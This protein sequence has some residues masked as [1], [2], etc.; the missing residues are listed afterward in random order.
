MGLSHLQLCSISDVVANTLNRIHVNEMF[1]C[2][3]NSI[4]YANHDGNI[5]IL[6]DRKKTFSRNDILVAFSKALGLSDLSELRDY[7]ENH[8]VIKMPIDALSFLNPF[9]RSRY[10]SF[11]WES[12]GKVF[13]GSLFDRQEL[14]VTN[15]YNSFKIPELIELA[16]F[17][18][19]GVGNAVSVKFISNDE[20]DFDVE[21]DY[22][23]KKS[24]DLFFIAQ[25]I[26]L[27]LVHL[28][29][30]LKYPLYIS[31]L[32][33]GDL[34]DVNELMHPDKKEVA[35]QISEILGSWFDLEF[36]VNVNHESFLDS[37]LTVSFSESHDE[38]IKKALFQTSIHRIYKSAL[39][40]LKDKHCRDPY[41]YSHPLMTG[42]YLAKWFAIED[43]KNGFFN[44]ELGFDAWASG[45]INEEVCGTKMYWMNIG[46]LFYAQL[47]KRLG[48]DG[49]LLNEYDVMEF[50]ESEI[51]SKLQKVQ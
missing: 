28:E 3:N 39:K 29:I 26:Y 43:S 7:L 14:A 44:D 12:F 23:L 47:D 40:I 19:V 2:Q 13:L 15:I 17:L 45:F 27:Q 22:S 18:G 49:Y 32:R 1:L 8:Q 35:A 24:F 20:G 16:G 6:D 38:R 31:N 21:V 48:D 33:L 9:S 37:E 36:D 25:S 11:L 30:K 5:Q 51:I 10:Y 50:I 41:I 34:L 4:V 46:I 42:D